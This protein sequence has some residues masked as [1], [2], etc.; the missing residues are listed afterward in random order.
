MPIKFPGK[1]DDYPSTVE[2]VVLFA[3]AAVVGYVLIRTMVNTDAGNVHPVKV[4][5]QPPAKQVFV[6]PNPQQ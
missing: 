2:V 5:K 3:L 6:Q 1:R 4:E